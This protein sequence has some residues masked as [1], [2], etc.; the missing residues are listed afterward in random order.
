MSQGMAEVLKQGT[1]EPLIVNLRD[2][3]G[4]IDDL[5][6]DVTNLRFDVIASDGTTFKV[7]NGVPS[8]VGT[9]AICLIDTTTGGGWPD[10]EYTLWIKY[11]DGSASPVLYAG[12]FRVEADY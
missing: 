6:T 7:T 5:A 3:L 1:I 9:K 11:T 2:R 8:T 4:T 12:K 10:D